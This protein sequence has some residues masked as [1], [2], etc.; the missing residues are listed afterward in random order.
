M[1]FS[2]LIATFVIALATSA[3]IAKLFSKSI[4]NILN[5]ILKDEIAGA[6]QRYILFAVLVVGVS[7]GVQL[8]KIEQYAEGYQPQRIERGVEKDQDEWKPPQLN[9]QTWTLEIYRCVIGS[10]QG[11][12]WAML[13]FF[14]VSLVAFVIVRGQEMKLK[15]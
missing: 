4:G 15:T 3:L 10:I 13:V 14:L 12:A 8:W 11:I 2:L 7:S 5:R 6:W 1:F 9:S